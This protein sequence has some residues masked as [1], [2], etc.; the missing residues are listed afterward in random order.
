MKKIVIMLGAI[1][2]LGMSACERDWVCQ[3]VDQNGNVSNR[4]I[5]DQLLLSARSKCRGMS[6]V[7]NENG[8]SQSCALQ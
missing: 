8:T 1:A 4:V 6:F 7:N 2:L 5:N 3:C